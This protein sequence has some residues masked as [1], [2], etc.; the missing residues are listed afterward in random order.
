M[1]TRLAYLRGEGI[2]LVVHPDLVPGL[3]V[4]AKNLGLRRLVPV[5]GDEP[6][7][8]KPNARNDIVLHCMKCGGQ[9]QPYQMLANIDGEPYN[10][11]EHERCHE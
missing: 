2:E 6:D 3:K 11:Y 10:S 9:G 7:R 5:A 8:S 4:V 1:K